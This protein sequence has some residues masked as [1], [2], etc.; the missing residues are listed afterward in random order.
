MKFY[1]VCSVI[2]VYFIYNVSCEQCNNTVGL[3]YVCEQCRGDMNCFGNCTLPDE[4]VPCYVYPSVGNW[5]CCLQDICG[6]PSGGAYCIFIVSSTPSPSKTSSNSPMV[7]SISMDESDTA[8]I[9]QWQVWIY[10]V[11]LFLVFSLAC[12][13]IVTLLL[14]ISRKKTQEEVP[15]YKNIQQSD[16]D[17][18]NK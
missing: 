5:S 9:N 6:T 7:P 16:L 1:V 15:I 14:K 3:S 11:I 2:L 13:V 8:K 10:I 18:L 4:L 17:Y 12:I